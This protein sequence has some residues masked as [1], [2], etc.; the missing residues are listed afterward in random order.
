LAN[1]LHLWRHA[2]FLDSVLT[3]DMREQRTIY[4]EDLIL[5]ITAGRP[6]LAH[7]RLPAGGRRQC[8]GDSSG[9]EAFI[10]YAR[11]RP[12]QIWGSRVRASAS[13]QGGG[14]ASAIRVRCPRLLPRPIGPARVIGIPQVPHTFHHLR[15]FLRAGQD[16]W[17]RSAD[18]LNPLSP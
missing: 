12:T 17:S 4:L 11:R 13:A 8:D 7:L 10:A 5:S 3:A 9:R 15:I 2:L 6:R 1:R 16:N 18:V 14:S